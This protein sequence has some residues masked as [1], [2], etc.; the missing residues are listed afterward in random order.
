MCHTTAER[1]Y[2][3][4]L[5]KFTVRYSNFP[6]YFDCTILSPWIVDQLY[7]QPENQHRLSRCLTY[8]YAQSDVR[9]VL[10]KSVK[11]KEKFV[12]RRGD[13]LVRNARPVSIWL[14]RRS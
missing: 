4:V 1:R 9:P 3:D 10:P 5:A 8:P 13:A 2:A 6:W 14:E 7:K 11:E 12:H